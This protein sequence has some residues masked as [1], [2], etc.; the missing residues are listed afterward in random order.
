MENRMEFAVSV[1]VLRGFRDIDMD[2]C[3][4][5]IKKAP[6]KIHNKNFKK[7]ILSFLKD[8]REASALNEKEYLLYQKKCIESE[9]EKL[10]V[11]KQ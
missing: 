8:Y 7:V 2:A 3:S 1:L 11:S 4:Y 6:K 10:D 5:A 9:I